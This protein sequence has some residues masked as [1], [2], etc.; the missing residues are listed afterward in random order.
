MK[1]THKKYI[2]TMFALKNYALIK[3][4][5]HKNQT[6]YKYENMIEH[7]REY[8]LRNHFGVKLIS[9]CFTLPSLFSISVIFQM[10]NFFYNIQHMHVLNKS[11]V[12]YYIEPPSIQFVMQA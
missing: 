4:E 12:W 1:G 2:H 10:M 11:C 7:V 3:E 5:R 8:S 6:G 9:F